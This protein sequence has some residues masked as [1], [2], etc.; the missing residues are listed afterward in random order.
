MQRWEAQVNIILARIGQHLERTGM[1]ETK[2]GR[3]AVSDPRLIGD[4]R[5]GR[6]PRPAM[7]ARIESYIAQRE[8]AR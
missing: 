3:C 7:V 4:L 2:F 8:G 5:R 1:A 6:I